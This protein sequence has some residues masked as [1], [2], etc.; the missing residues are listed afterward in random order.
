MQGSMK[1]TQSRPAML[2][3]LARVTPGR[4]VRAG[5]GQRF[6]E[7][8]TGKQVQQDLRAQRHCDVLSTPRRRAQ[9]LGSG[10]HHHAL[11][12]LPKPTKQ[13]TTWLG[14]WV[15][16]HWRPTVSALD[17]PPHPALGARQDFIS[18]PW[19]RALFSSLPSPWGVPLLRATTAAITTRSTDQLQQPTVAM[20]LLGHAAAGWGPRCDT[21]REGSQAPPQ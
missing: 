6:R 1:G 8:C 19:C 11:P 14:M 18:T 20:S 10:R 3:H 7:G 13:K 16:P 5:N 15:K 17:A 21:P 2:I 9:P 4:W 12:C